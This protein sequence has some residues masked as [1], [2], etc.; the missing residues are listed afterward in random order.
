MVFEERGYMRLHITALLCISL[1]FWHQA[2]FP[3]S[4]G[5]LCSTAGLQLS[6]CSDCHRAQSSDHIPPVW[7]SSMRSSCGSSTNRM[8]RVRPG[9][10][11]AK[12]KWCHATKATKARSV[13]LV[14]FDFEWSWSRRRTVPPRQRAT[15]EVGRT[16]GNIGLRGTAIASQTPTAALSPQPWWQCHDAQLLPRQHDGV[17]P[18]VPGHP[19][20]NGRCQGFVASAAAVPRRKSLWPC[21]HQGPGARMLHGCLG[22]R[23]SRPLLQRPSAVKG[24]KL[25]QLLADF[26]KAPCKTAAANS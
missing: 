6:M 5:A 26:G 25:Q 24:S 12:S 8:T 18:V 17:V 20:S 19:P 13:R 15:R 21:S 23:Q 1:K 4:V 2:A 3:A 11:M 22:P 7:G 9:Q 14:R 16:G 10:S